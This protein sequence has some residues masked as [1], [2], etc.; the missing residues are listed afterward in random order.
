METLRTHVAQRVCVAVDISQA[1][2]SR[3]SRHFNPPT[4]SPHLRAGLRTCKRIAARA[5][6][7]MAHLQLAGLPTDDLHMKIRLQWPVLANEVL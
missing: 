3:E 6:A 2:L 7:R 4:V 1:R 5:N